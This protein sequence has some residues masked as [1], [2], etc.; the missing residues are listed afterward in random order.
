MI[1]EEVYVCIGFM[2]F[3][4][5]CILVG[6]EHQDLTP[7]DLHSDQGES[8]VYPYEGLGDIED[9]EDYLDLGELEGL[10]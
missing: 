4:V 7:S 9:H 3:A 8:S 10:V 6:S 1:A 2:A 5:M